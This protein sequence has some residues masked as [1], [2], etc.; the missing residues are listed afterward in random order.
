MK[1]VAVKKSNTPEAAMQRANEYLARM[2]ATR[3]AESFLAKKMVLPLKVGVDLG[4]SNIVVTVLDGNDEPV[5]FALRAARV[6]RDGI[7]VNFMEAAK[8]LEE[9]K[10]ELEGRLGVK[11][12]RAATAIPPG[13]MQGNVK[14][15]SNVVMAAGF[16]VIK[17]IDEPEAAALMLGINKGAVVDIG[18]GTTG[19][20]VIKDGSVAYSVDEPTGG[21][22]M[23]LVV[24]GGAKLGFEE[25]EAYKLVPENNQRVFAMIRP[26]IEKMAQI[27]KESLR[28]KVDALYLAGGASALPGIDAVFENYTGIKSYKPENPILVTPIGIAMSIP[29]EEG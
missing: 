23:T 4:T 18:G 16:S 6:V 26:V 28:E 10:A 27:T 2:E 19:V 22:H 8:I 9:L 13:I 25:A 5:A 20:S 7:V 17:V 15:I 24:A 29:A 14:V 21:T 3:T 12:E 1:K 11:L